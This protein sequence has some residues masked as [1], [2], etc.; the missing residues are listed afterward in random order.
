MR[1]TG[2][3]KVAALFGYPVEHTL[4]PVMQ[5]AAFQ[6]LGMDCCYLPFPVPPEQLKQAVESVRALSL[7]GVNL[8]VPHKEAVIP[9]LDELDKEAAAIGAVNTIVNRDGKLI[10]HNTDGRGFMRSLKE[11]GVQA[12]GKKVLI[13]GAGGSSRAIGFYLSKETKMLTLYNRSREKAEALASDLRST[14]GAVTVSAELSDLGGFDILINATPLGLKECDQMPLDPDT[15]APTIVVCD[16]IYHKT[17][18]LSRAE[19]K[20][21]K[22][23]GGSGMLLWQGA[24]AFELWTGVLP[25]IEIM[26]SALLNKPA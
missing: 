16:L 12:D 2:T 6:H 3:T 21:C 5:N 4:S 20:G 13:I 17:P 26:R 7:L 24:L 11:L 10:G 22:T 8:T 14:G 23:V 25:P 15:L 1:I 18:L 9:F 19:A